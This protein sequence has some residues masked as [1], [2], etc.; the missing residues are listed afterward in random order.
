MQSNECNDEG[1][2]KVSHGIAHGNPNDFIHP[3]LRAH[4]VYL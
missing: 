1:G 2:M 3:E 4:E